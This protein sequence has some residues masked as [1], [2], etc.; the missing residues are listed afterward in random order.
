MQPAEPRFDAYTATCE[1]PHDALVQVLLEAGGAS[2]VRP[3]RGLHRF[4]HRLAVVGQ[5]DHEVGAVSW[6]G[7][8]G[9]LAML[10]VKGEATPRAV[11][12]LREAVPH[13]R[14]TRVDSCIDWDAPR[15]FSRLYRLCRSV[16]KAH[17]IIGG[18]AG[19]W[20]DFPEKG[21]TLYLGSPASPV[22]ARLYEKGLQPQYQH[23]A[24]PEW[25][26]LEVQVRPEKDARAAFAALDAR[27][28]WGASRWSRELGEA[29]LREE[30]ERVRAGTTYRLSTRD[31]ALR[32]MLRQYGHHLASLA[33]DLGGWA[34]VGLVLRDELS[35]LQARPGRGGQGLRGQS[36]RLPPESL[37]TPPGPELE[38][39]V[40]PRCH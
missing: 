11:Q 28:V 10:E 17:R 24:R 38:D 7:A 37:D 4:A 3:G 2:S 29:A 36:A 14:V 19:D 18:K 34:E 40:V 26:R 25:V 5:D 13:H 12:R 20:E 21:R 35:A 8:H 1:A 16:K 9:A 30:L 6:G 33:V 22:R 31:Q 32:W 39:E 27:Q 15:A 23:L